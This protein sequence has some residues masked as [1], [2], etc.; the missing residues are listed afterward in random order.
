MKSRLRRG[1][2]G[3]TLEQRLGS[4][5]DEKDPL[6][7]WIHVMQRSV[8][9]KTES[10]TMVERQ[11]SVDV[12]GL[13][14]VQL[15]SLVSVG[16]HE[17]SGAAIVLTPDGVKRRNENCIDRTREMG[18]RV[19]CNVCWSSLAIEIGSTEFGETCCT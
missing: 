9:P 5:I 10:W 1:S 6:M 2:W 3:V 13:G 4:R 12:E 8:C 14:N 19:Q 11:I 18:S 7:S 15:W 17:R 16:H